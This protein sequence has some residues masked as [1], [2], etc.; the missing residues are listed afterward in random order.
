MINYL[1]EYYLG[2][3]LLEACPTKLSAFMSGTVN[4]SF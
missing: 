3:V 2:L 4:S 1:I